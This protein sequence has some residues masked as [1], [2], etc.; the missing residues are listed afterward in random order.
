VQLIIS[1]VLDNGGEAILAA[2]LAVSPRHLRRLFDEHMGITPAQFARSRRAHFARRLLDDTDLPVI[3]VAFASGFGSL[4]QF[5]RTM[6]EVFR[7]PPN[8]LRARRR[9]ADRLIADGGVILRIPV[10]AP[11]DWPSVVAMLAQRAIAGVESVDGGVYRRTISLDGSPGMLELSWGAPDHLL[12][13]AHLPYWEGLIHVADKAAAIAGVTDFSSSGHR[14]LAGDPDLAAIVRRR[15]GLQVPGVWSG[16]E[17]AC[18]ELAT[19]R[20]GGVNG[21]VQRYGVAVPGL[22]HG[23]THLFPSP[24]ALVNVPGHPSVRNLARAVAGDRI[25]LGSWLDPNALAENIPDVDGERVALRL[26]APDAFPRDDPRLRRAL[27]SLSISG[28]AAERWRPF[29]GLAATYLIE[30]GAELASMA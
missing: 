11:Y 24:E 10:P 5:N 9:R 26:G 2:R 12:L 29:R 28:E 18:A 17:A 21:I 3:D 16:F 1:G 13:R 8:A 23:L 14:R 30:H 7:E 19:A 22:G 4:R 25:E 20:T 15:P 27:E 6:R